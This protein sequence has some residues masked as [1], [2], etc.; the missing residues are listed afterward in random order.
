MADPRFWSIE[1]AAG[2][3]LVLGTA[4]QFPGL[5][6]FWIRG[7]QRGGLPPTPA[8]Y[9]WERG[10]VLAAIILTALGFA[11]FEAQLQNTGGQILARVGVTACVFAGILGVAAEALNLS[12]AGPGLYPLIVVYVVLTFLAQA[13]IGGGLLQAGAVAPWIGWATLIWNSAW[14]VVLPLVTPRDIYFPVLHQVAP[15][16]IGIALLWKTP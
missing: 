14:L 16:V 4:V 2:F 9:A 10:F 13:A 7:G 1:R 11:L 12:R 3:V 8:Y 15:L 6:M 5:L